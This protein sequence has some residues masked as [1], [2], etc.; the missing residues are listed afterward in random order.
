MQ[1]TR[2]RKSPEFG[3]WIV[4]KQDQIGTKEHKD[5]QSLH[6]FATQLP[7]L[8]QYGCS[9]SPWRRVH[10]HGTDYAVYVGEHLNWGRRTGLG[11]AVSRR[12]LSLSL[13]DGRDCGGSTWKLLKL[14]KITRKWLRMARTSGC[15]EVSNRV[16]HQ[17]PEAIQ[18]KGGWRSPPSWLCLAA[19]SSLCQT[20]L[21]QGPSLPKAWSFCRW[22]QTSLEWSACANAASN[23]H[24]KNLGFHPGDLLPWTWMCFFKAVCFLPCPSIF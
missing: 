7:C 11:S 1:P 15:M 14:N 12:A 10:F 18:E 2:S 4:L 5:I 3:I 19:C 17:E 23:W 24:P 22:P 8:W 13:E 20:K 21:F 9:I 6:R 16:K